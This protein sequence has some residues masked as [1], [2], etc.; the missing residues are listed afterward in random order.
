[1][2]RLRLDILAELD[3]RNL[4]A[5]GAM[6]GSVDANTA[7][8]TTATTSAITAFDYWV[9]VGSGTPPGGPVDVGAIARWLE[10]RQLNFNAKMLARRISRIGSRDWREGNPNAFE[11]AIEAWEQTPEFTGL[12]DRSANQYGQAWVDI[13][14]NNLNRKN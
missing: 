10:V 11:T 12:G 7:Q 13:V 9:N 1:M 8:T 6:R 3:R 4:N 14:F 2:N 5:T